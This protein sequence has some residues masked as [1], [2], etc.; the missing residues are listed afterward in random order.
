MKFNVSARGSWIFNVILEATKLKEAICSA[1][2]DKLVH[3]F[4]MET[5]PIILSSV[6]K[7]MQNFLHL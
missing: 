1:F 7:I 2:L 6:A 4:N 3:A 5:D